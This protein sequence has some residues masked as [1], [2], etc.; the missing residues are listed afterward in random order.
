[1][2]D[3]ATPEVRFRTEAEEKRRHEGNKLTK[4]LAFS[5][6]A[7]VGVEIQINR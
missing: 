3:I 5:D 6:C 7:A 4:R 1:M 2:N